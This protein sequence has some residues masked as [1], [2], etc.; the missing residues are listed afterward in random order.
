MTRDDYFRRIGMLVRSGSVEKLMAAWNEPHRFY[1][2]ES[3]LQNLLTLVDAR[4]RSLGVSVL[5]TYVLTLLAFYHDAVYD[6]RRNDN[7]E[8][9][10]Q[11]FLADKMCD[12]TIA[13]RVVAGILATKDHTKPC[14][15]PIVELFLDMD[16]NNLLTGTLSSLITDGINVFKEYQFYDWNDFRYGRIKF[17]NEMAP[18]LIKR[19]GGKSSVMEYLE[20]MYLSWKPN[21]AVYP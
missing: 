20:W 8:K 14:G 4:S 19:S 6:P 17:I 9:S 5:E 16:V 3:H 18:W 12:D 13:D 21:I 11:M 15:D 10:A 1:H 7:E 2:N